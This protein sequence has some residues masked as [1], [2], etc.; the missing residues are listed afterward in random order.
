MS[1]WQHRDALRTLARQQAPEP[2]ALWQLQ[3]RIEQSQPLG[4]LACIRAAA[5]DEKL[6]LLI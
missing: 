3:R 4:E 1:D 2:A 5:V 6:L